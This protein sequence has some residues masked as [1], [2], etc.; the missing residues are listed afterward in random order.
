MNGLGASK[1]Q[2]SRLV[3]TYDCFQENLFEIANIKN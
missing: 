1:R 3:L 2:I